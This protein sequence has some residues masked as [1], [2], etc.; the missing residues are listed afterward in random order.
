MHFRVTSNQVESIR[1]QVIARAEALVVHLAARVQEASRWVRC[2]V[3]SH[4]ATLH[5]PASAHVEARRSSRSGARCNARRSWAP[6][7]SVVPTP[8][9][10]PV[11][12][13]TAR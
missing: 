13:V 11:I 10:L 8:C 7:S 9:V 3:L 1:A 12:T 6:F 2:V 5:R 4:R